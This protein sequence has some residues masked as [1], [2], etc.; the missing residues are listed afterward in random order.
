VKYNGYMSDLGYK[1]SGKPRNTGMFKPGVSGNPKGR[2]KKDYRLTELAR[3]YTPE[4]IMKLFEIA[5]SPK[6]KGQDAIK[7]LGILLDRA[8]GKVT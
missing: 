7:A 4:A 8:Y 3:S 1:K 2:P 5:N 6:S